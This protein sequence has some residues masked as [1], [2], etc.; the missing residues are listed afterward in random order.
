MSRYGIIACVI[1]TVSAACLNREQRIAVAVFDAARQRVVA[2]TTQIIGAALR[3]DSSDLLRLA[4]DSAAVRDLTDITTTD[5]ALLQAAALGLSPRNLELSACAGR[6]YFSFEYKGQ[7][8]EGLAELRYVRDDW[9][10][11]SIRIPVAI[12]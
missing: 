12:D 11:L 5:H 8:T 3:G 4:V 10:I 9:R 1:L 2:N 7:S 6:L